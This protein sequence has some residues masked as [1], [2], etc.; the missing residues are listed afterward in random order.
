MQL[1][2]YLHRLTHIEDSGSL[3]NLALQVNGKLL[4]PLD[5][6]TLVD[7]T[8]HPGGLQAIT[9]LWVRVLESL[10]RFLSIH[11]LPVNG[12]PAMVLAEETV[13]HYPLRR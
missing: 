5:L 10:R 13:G 11:V 3:P 9:L 2:L 6:Q 7:A 1:G 8:L 4:V 12:N